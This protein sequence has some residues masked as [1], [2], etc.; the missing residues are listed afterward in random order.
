MY[1]YTNL[2]KKR[3]PN[4]NISKYYYDNIYKY[5]GSEFIFTPYK[6]NEQNINDGSKSIGFERYVS[7]IMSWN[8]YEKINNKCDNYKNFNKIKVF[9][10]QIDYG[11]IIGIHIFL[12]PSISKVAYGDNDYDLNDIKS[13]LNFICFNFFN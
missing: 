8:I 10:F 9:L 2:Y 6:I 1:N 13:F 3:F 11:T 4:K 12:N 7:N 5:N